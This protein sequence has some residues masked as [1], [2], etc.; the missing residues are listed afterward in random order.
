M[1]S[2]VSPY[3]RGGVGGLKCPWTGG[4]SRRAGHGLG[5]SGDDQTDQSMLFACVTAMAPTYAPGDCVKPAEPEE[6]RQPGRGD[7]ARFVANQSLD[8]DPS[9]R[10]PRGFGRFFL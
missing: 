4:R 9:E 5:G 2:V 8:M 7:L 10:R 1:E 6:S 3:D